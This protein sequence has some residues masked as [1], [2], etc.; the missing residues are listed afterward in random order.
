MKFNRSHCTTIW[1][2]LYQYLRKNSLLILIK[3]K[4]EMDTFEV[5][6][7]RFELTQNNAIDLEVN[8]SMCRGIETWNRIFLCSHLMWTIRAYTKKKYSIKPLDLF[9]AAMRCCRVAGTQQIVSNWTYEQ[10]S[11]TD[12]WESIKMS[13]CE[14]YNYYSSSFVYTRYKSA[15][16]TFFFLYI[17]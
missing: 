15:E 8:C 13:D 9:C 4:D 16:A 3:I 1:S 2:R 7:D 14:S 12:N 17:N 11:L 5:M 6:Y 10:H